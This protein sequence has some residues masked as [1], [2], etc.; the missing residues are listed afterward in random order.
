MI[1]AIDCVVVRISER[2]FRIEGVDDPSVIESVC[3]SNCGAIVS[4][5]ALG[6][7]SSKP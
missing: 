2:E 3:A 7:V 6:S 5:F 1:T 4:N